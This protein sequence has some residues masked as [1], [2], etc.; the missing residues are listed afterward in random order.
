MTS[1]Q[2]EA[3]QAAMEL[4]ETDGEWYY[5]AALERVG[6]AQQCLRQAGVYLERYRQWVKEQRERDAVQILREEQGA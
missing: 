5:Q 6:D 2:D 3:Q 4:G 1:G